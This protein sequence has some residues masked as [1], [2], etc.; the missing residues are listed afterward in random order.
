MNR[1]YPLLRRNEKYYC[2]NEILCTMLHIHLGITKTVRRKTHSLNDNMYVIFLHI[3]IEEKHVV[4]MYMYYK[5]GFFYNIWK[6]M[7]H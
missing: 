2:N 5:H 4:N 1:S 7:V 3:N 6:L